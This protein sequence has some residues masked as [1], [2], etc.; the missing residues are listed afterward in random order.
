MGVINFPQPPQFQAVNGVSSLLHFR[1][2]NQGF[3]GPQ[4]NTV[5]DTVT[6]PG[7]NVIYDGQLYSII[8][9]GRIA[10]ATGTFTTR[11]QL[12]NAGVLSLTLVTANKAAVGG[13]SGF[14]LELLMARI[15]ANSI[16]AVAKVWYNIA[17]TTATPAAA[18][19]LMNRQLASAD[20]TVNQ[21]VTFD[22]TCV[23]GDSYTH[24]W[25]YAYIQ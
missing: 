6:I 10:N 18:T 4:T 22:I 23:G 7:N 11:L 5:V 14:L 24:R 3:S 2:F 17:D 9:Q 12:F 25:S 16:D 21:T 15:N 8:F 19:P 20:F 13:V 1:G